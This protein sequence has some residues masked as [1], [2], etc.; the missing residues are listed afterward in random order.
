VDEERLISPDVIRRL[1]HGTLRPLHEAAVGNDRR[2]PQIS[3]RLVELLRNWVQADLI[4]RIKA[5][6]SEDPVLMGILDAP[7]LNDNLLAEAP[8]NY[9][10]RWLRR[11]QWPGA[12][13][14]A[15]LPRG[16]I[17]GDPNLSNIFVS[18][19]TVHQDTA[20]ALI[21]FEY[22]KAGPLDSPYD[23]LARIECELLHGQP[24]EHRRLILVDLALSAGIT[25]ATIPLAATAPE[26]KATY[27]SVVIVRARVQELGEMTTGWDPDRFATGYFGTL[28]ARGLRY[29]TYDLRDDVERSGVLF[30]CQLLALRLA[31]ENWQRFRPCIEP[32]GVSWTRGA[33]RLSDLSASGA[34]VDAVASGAYAG[35]LFAGQHNQ[36]EWCLEVTLLI[37]EVSP[38]AWLGFGLGVSAEN[39]ETSG[40]HVLATVGADRRWWLSIVSH[41]DSRHAAH[42]RP[43]TPVAVGRIRMQVKVTNRDVETIFLTDHPE[44]GCQRL[45]SHAPMTRYRG[46][47][48]F[49]VHGAKVTLAS[50]TVRGGRTTPIQ[51]LITNR[52]EARRE[53]QQ[54]RDGLAP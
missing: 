30:W 14:I 21:D 29:L 47:F 23:D 3:L 17:H 15:L 2:L 40:I 51:K 44:H 4:K 38:L 6:L 12:D 5:R 20:I 9:V 19:G 31:T 25:P 48:S 10:G 46:S 24:W 33:G 52:P 39:P 11:G 13:G 54:H 37:Q 26:A 1:L 50:L 28:L 42:G 35:L 27:E 49:L 45:A 8:T 34:I 18:R 7:Y 43:E 41:D 53:K 36:S 22:C 16:A 32:T